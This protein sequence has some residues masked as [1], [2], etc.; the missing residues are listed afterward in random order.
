MNLSRMDL[1]PTG[2]QVVKVQTRRKETLNYQI[3]IREN[4]RISVSRR[5]KFTL[6]R[7]FKSRDFYKETT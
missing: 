5:N 6:T 7:H 4:T 2:K 3:L 1:Y